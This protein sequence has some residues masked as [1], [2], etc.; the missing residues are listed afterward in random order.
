MTYCQYSHYSLSS[1]NTYNTPTHD[2]YGNTWKSGELKLYFSPSAGGFK[3]KEKK[4]QHK[5]PPPPLPSCLNAPPKVE[6]GQSNK[7]L[8]RN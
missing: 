6:I 2:E 1:I 5:I 4:L 8:L 7:T 3:K